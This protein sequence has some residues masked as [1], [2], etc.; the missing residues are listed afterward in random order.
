VQFHQ[1]ACVIF[2]R[3]FIRCTPPI[4]APVQYHNIA[5]LT[6]LARSI[7]GSFRVRERG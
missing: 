2:V 4:L 3:F 7:R 1:L 6:A 5:G